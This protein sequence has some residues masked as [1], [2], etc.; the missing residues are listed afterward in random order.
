MRENQIRQFLE[1]KGAYSLDFAL[2][3]HC[4]KMG[5]RY[6]NPLSCAGGSGGDLENSNIESR[7]NYLTNSIDNKDFATNDLR[8]THGFFGQ[9]PTNKPNGLDGGKSHSRSNSNNV[10]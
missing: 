4:I 2:M 6:E 8:R 5:H 7:K 1:D 3:E 10:L 9:T